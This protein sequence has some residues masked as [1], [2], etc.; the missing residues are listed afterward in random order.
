MASTADDRS[1]AELMAELSRETGRLVRKEVELATV[2]LSD[3]I[4]NVSRS[5]SV[6]AAGG[7]LAHAGLLVL[8]AAIVA[9]L[10][11]L[12]MQLWLSALVV[13]IMT[14]GGGYALITSGVSTLRQTTFMPK[15]TIE[16]LK[17][18]TKWTTGQGA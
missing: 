4:S 3:K 14:M 15:H 16:T 8:L 1:L 5:A 10:T 18:S 12:G 9:G 13:A 2:E 6:A 17:E 7:V 11:Q